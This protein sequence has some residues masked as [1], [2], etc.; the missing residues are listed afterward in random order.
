MD[1]T[2]LRTLIH[3]SELGS[4]SKAADRL[5][6]AQPAL[7]RQIRMLEA[8]LKAPLF[9]RHGRGMELTELG[10]RVL[11]P[12]GRVLD[13]LDSIRGMAQEDR[14]SLAGRVRFGMTPT[15]AD[16]MT[17]PLA[18]AVRA[19][20][21]RLS[22]C[23]SSAFSGH[24]LD[25]LKREELDCSVSYDPQKS[26][27]L[28]IRP[29]ILETLLLVGGPDRGLRMDR[30][31]RFAELAHETLV[32]PSPLHGLRELADRNAQRAGIALSPAVEA[33]SYGAMIDLVGNGFGSTILPLAPIYERVRAGAL[34]AAPLINPEPTRRLVIA[35]S[36]DRPI[37]PATRFAGESF[38]AIA[39]DLVEQGIWA[40][41][42]LGPDE[43]A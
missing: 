28:R 42:V 5:G 13:E 33:D 7:S 15:V 38:A 16:I 39:A 30:P 8:E 22:L 2:Q 29:I 27:S 10:R 34:T 12:A 26:R 1:I 21:P 9:V 3:V 6:I 36:A 24:L 17:V 35:Y 18:R 37:T 31:M 23:F 14:V 40:G 41:R 19:A 25:W 4:L 11:E 32:L 43:A 20:H